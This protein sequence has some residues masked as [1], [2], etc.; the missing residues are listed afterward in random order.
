MPKT[1][2]LVSIPESSYNID[3][4][5]DIIE[6][7][8]SEH[9]M[10]VVLPEYFYTKQKTKLNERDR[11]VGKALRVE[12][13]KVVADDPTV[14]SDMKKLVKAA[15]KN[16]AHIFFSGT[17]RIGKRSFPTSGFIVTPSEKEPSV[18]VVRRKIMESGRMGAHSIKTVKVAGFNV[19]PLICEDVRAVYWGN[20]RTPSKTRLKDVDVIAVSAHNYVRGGSTRSNLKNA[21]EDVKK[22]VKMA[23]RAALVMADSA[24]HAARW[25]LP[26]KK[27]DNPDGIYTPGKKSEWKEHK[28][29]SYFTH[30]HRK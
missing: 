3:R 28:G 1:L 29:V 13:G 18:A 24:T 23:K 2:K 8:K 22:N 20:F 12:N 26:W 9:P 17:E 21:Y 4:I 7:E 5:V 15:R 19:L 14:K 11:E 6:E 27:K 30:I 16:N 25:L 10:L